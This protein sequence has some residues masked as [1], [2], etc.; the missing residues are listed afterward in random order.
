MKYISKSKKCIKEDITKRPNQKPQT[1]SLS[2]KHT[3]AI[4]ISLRPKTNPSL[5]IRCVHLYAGAKT[6]WSK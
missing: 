5:K 3:R 2:G 6:T 1:S 4:K